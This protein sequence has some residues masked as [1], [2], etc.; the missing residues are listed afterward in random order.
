MGLM[1]EDL[2]CHLHSLIGM[3]IGRIADDEVK[4]SAGGIML[5]DEGEEIL[6]P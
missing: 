1:E 4:G 3:D 2:R 6:L 5:L